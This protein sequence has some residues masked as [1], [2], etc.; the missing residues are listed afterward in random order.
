MSIQV[1]HNSIF[2][3]LDIFLYCEIRYKLMIAQ[4]FDMNGHKNNVLN[5]KLITEFHLMKFNAH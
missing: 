4:H 1:K 3:I 2:R 5:I